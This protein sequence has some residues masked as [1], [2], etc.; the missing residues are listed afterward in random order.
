MDYILFDRSI[1]HGDKFKEIE[2]SNLMD[3][4]KRNEVRVYFTPEFLEETLAFGLK[5]RDALKTQVGFLFSLNSTHWFRSPEMIVEAELGLKY[6]HHLYYLLTDEEILSIKYGT[7][8]YVEGG[9]S[10]NELKDTLR[11]VHRNISIRED[12][13]KQRLNLRRSVPHGQYDFKLHFENNAE[14]FIENRLMK[15]HQ[16]SSNY[17]RRWKSSRSECK[18]TEQYL[19]CWFSTAF[20][21]IVN[22][23]LRVDKNDRADAAQL[24]YLLWADVMVSDDK[25]FMKEAFNL[26]YSDTNKK[27]LDL[28]KFFQYMANDFP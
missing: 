22:H 23:T 26:L 1:F 12:F 10:E 18:F 19:R 4:V 6:V 13:R 21:P 11:K 5:D 16:D 14:W 27:F 3:L 17:L 20:L 9:I 2:Q 7:E 28:P 8:T 24:A 25:R 15:Y